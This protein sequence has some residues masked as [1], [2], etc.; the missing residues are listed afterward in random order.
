[1]ISSELKREVE[2]IKWWHKIDLGNGVITPGRDNTPEKLKRIGMIQNLSGK[3]V[4]DIGAWDGFF[5][6]E[7]ERRGA[8]RVLAVDSFEWKRGQKA[9]F[10]LARKVLGSKVEDKEIDVMDI[11]P[12]TI[13]IFDYVLFLGVLYH[14]RHPLLALE[15]VSSVT[16]DQLVVETHIEL[17]GGKRPVMVFYPENELLNDRTNWWGLNPSAVES[18]LKDVGF[19]EV[20]IIYKMPLRELGLLFCIVG[21]T[22]GS[23][24]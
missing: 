1:M 20:K 10:E 11:S 5:S 2:N 22:G 17:I 14:L 24:F 13:G 21:L 15:K 12:E 7:A 4:L 18:M 19:R 3:S 9:G 6:F 8:S 23:R 16:K